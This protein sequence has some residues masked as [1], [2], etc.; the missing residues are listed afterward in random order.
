MNALIGTRP[1]TFDRLLGA[2]ADLASA[3]TG[4]DRLALYVID[5]DDGRRLLPVASTVAT[6]EAETVSW[7]P[8][9]PSPL[10]TLIEEGRPW[11]VADSSHH[12][13]PSAWRTIAPGA[14]LVVPVEADGFVLGVMV[15]G[16]EQRP[17]FD[18]DL[19]S[20]ASGFA[21]LAA[22]VLELAAAT[23]IDHAVAFER[24]LID[25][26]VRTTLGRVLAAIN[27][28][29]G[30]LRLVADDHIA[31]DAAR[32]DALSQQGLASLRLDIARL[33]ASLED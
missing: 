22:G 1:D 31:A 10:E 4:S 23:T 27:L 15:L 25:A 18:S 6:P 24:E 11:E 9:L 12:H 32:I 2:I 30:I 26:E 16:W 28:R 19:C 3:A 29:A 20:R 33:W 17:C 8:S 7:D 14:A 5:E 13:F 21:E